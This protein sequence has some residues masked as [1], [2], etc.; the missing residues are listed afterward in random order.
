MN[1]IHI[2]ENV[3]ECEGMNPHIPKRTP[4]LGIGVLMDSQIF[5]KQFEE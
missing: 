4:T 1:H 3:E 5:K 2:L